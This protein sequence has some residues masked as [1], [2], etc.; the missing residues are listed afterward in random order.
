MAKHLQAVEPGIWRR[1][2]KAGVVSRFLT[3]T[4][5]LKGQTKFERTG[6]SSV[7]DARRLRAVRMA[8]VTTGTALPGGLVVNVLLDRLLADYVANQRPSLRTVRGH[9]AQLRAAIGSVKVK[10]LTPERIEAMQDAWAAITGKHAITNATIN[11][12]CEALRRALNLA[13]QKGTIAHRPWI[14]RLKTKPIQARY[15]QGADQAQLSEF[16]PDYV[17][18]LLEFA[19]LFGVRKGQLSRTLKTMVDRA[20]V[21]VCWPGDEAKN[22]EPHPMP[23]DTAGWAIVERQLDLH[24][25]C[26]YLFHGRYCRPGR[27]VSGRYGCVGDFKKAWQTACRK[28]GMPIG[29]KAGGIVF[30]HTRN[31]AVTDMLSGDTP[32]TPHDAMAISNHKTL[33]MIS[34]YNL[35][36]VEALRAR[37][38]S[39]RVDRTQHVETFRQAAEKA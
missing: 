39:S 26:P 33:S 22:E 29:R 24:P 27:T 4:Y 9:V 32:M 36:N 5:Q 8:A 16:L 6:T 14:R 25:W 31:T 21:M 11:K 37:L 3:I 15:I 7:V 28:A 34:H 35:G 17:V 23:L 18:V 2:S 38:A 10:D 1:V 20:R 30:H 12:R 19:R 13:K